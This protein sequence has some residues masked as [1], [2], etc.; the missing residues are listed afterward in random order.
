ML[1]FNVAT[2]VVGVPAP[3][4]IGVEG[5]DDLSTFSVGWIGAA[6]KVKV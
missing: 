1:D 6:W 3:R 5:N 4:R 2:N